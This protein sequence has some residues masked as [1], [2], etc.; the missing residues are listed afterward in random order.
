MTEITSV[1]LKVMLNVITRFLAD[2]VDCTSNC[3][4]YFSIIETNSNADYVIFNDF[5]VKFPSSEPQFLKAQKL[6]LPT[7][8]DYNVDRETHHISSYHDLGVFYAFLVLKVGD[9]GRYYK[10]P[11]PVTEEFQVKPVS[12]KDAS[13]KKF[14]SDGLT[15]VAWAKGSAR[16][17]P[18]YRPLSEEDKNPIKW[19]ATPLQDSLDMID[20]CTGKI[21]RSGKLHSFYD[22]ETADAENY[23]FRMCFPSGDDYR[24]TQIFDIRDILQI[25]DDK[26]LTN[27]F[28]DVAKKF[29][30][31]FSVG[32]RYQT[33]DSNR[34]PSP[35]RLI[36]IQNMNTELYIFI[37]TALLFY[38]GAIGILFS[39]FMMILVNLWKKMGKRK[40]KKKDGILDDNDDYDQPTS[41]SAENEPSYSNSENPTEFV[42]D[43][44]AAAVCRM[45]PYKKEKSLEKTQ[46][47]SETDSHKKQPELS[48]PVSTMLAPETPK[49]SSAYAEGSVYCFIKN[50][51]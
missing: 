49:E 28:Y 37:G 14:L 19:F 9:S 26:N 31:R 21:L 5:F 48:T 15:F 6:S 24:Y 16:T 20:Q 39:I 51:D 29:K 36:F 34:S 42:N 44:R 2:H 4:A 45:K 41:Y 13:K 25:I 23:E 40:A 50:K 47:S 27:K 46:N 8:D 11:W 22:N 32:V 7:A 38:V 10:I 18:M 17:W 35:C 33:A 1:F 43:H 30:N 3:G 12:V